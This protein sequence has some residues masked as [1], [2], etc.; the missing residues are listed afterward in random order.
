MSSRYTV[1]SDRTSPIERECLAYGAFQWT[2]ELMRFI[3]Q[4]SGA[5]VDG[6]RECA[7]VH[8]KASRT[9]R[10]RSR[11]PG[12]FPVN[13]LDYSYSLPL[14]IEQI[15][16]GLAWLAGESVAYGVVRPDRIFISDEGHAVVGDFVFPELVKSTAKFRPLYSELHAVP[17]NAR[18]K[19]LRPSPGQ[20]DLNSVDLYSWSCTALE[21]V[22]GGRFFP[23]RNRLLAVLSICLVMPFFQ[24]KSAKDVT[25]AKIQ[26]QTLQLEDY[27]CNAFGLYPDLWNLLQPFWEDGADG[28]LAAE[29]VLRRLQ[30]TLAEE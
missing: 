25:E 11:R 12:R 3:R 7:R 1:G 26:G 15:L 20:I 21:I 24:Y 9:I 30:S 14:K 23:L 22:S 19:D 5:S 2:I 28:R 17:D 6:K 16:S 10:P 8:G 4:L 29:D 27:S 18:Y 13:P